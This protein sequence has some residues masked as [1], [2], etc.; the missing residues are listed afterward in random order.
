MTF[1]SDASGIGGSIT[2]NGGT[3]QIGAGGTAGSIGNKA[4]SLGGNTM[5]FNRS[6]NISYSGA[7]SGTSGNVTK[8]GAGTL[9]LSGN[10]A[11]TGALTVAGGTISVGVATN[12]GGGT[13]AISNGGKL[14]TSAGFT[15]AR[16]I[17]MATGGG[18]IEVSTAGFTN[19]AGLNGSG[20]LLKTGAGTLV[21]GTTAG[22]YSG[23]ATIG[24]GTLVANTTLSSADVT[25]SNTGTLMG[26]GTLDTVIVQSGG[27][28]SPGNSPGTL[29]VGAL[30][31][32][33]GGSYRWEITAAPGSAGTDWDLI[34][35]NGGGGLITL[36]ATSESKFTIDVVGSSPTGFSAGTSYT[37]DIIDAGSWSTAFTTNVFAINTN[38][39]SAAG[40]LG[41]WSLEDNSGNLRLVYTALATDYNVTVD[42]GATN[43]GAATGGA[44][45]F[46]GGVGV[47]KLG[48]GTL[49]MTNPLNDYT[50]VTTVKAGTVS[51]TANAPT[52]G[53]GSL[54][55]NTNAVAVGDIAAAN[56][57]GFNFGAAVTNDHGLNIVAGTGAADRTIGTTI[58]SGT[59]VQAGAV[60]LST[61]ATFTAASGG[62]LSV[63]GVI[64]GAGSATISG[65]GGTVDFTGN[66]TT[67]TGTTTLSSGTLAGRQRQRPRHRRPHP[68]RWPPGFGQ[69]HRLHSDQ[70]AHGRRQC[71]IRPSIRRDRIADALRCARPR[72]RNPQ[73]RR[74]QQHDAVGHHQR[75]RRRGV[76]QNG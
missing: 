31:L 5:V 53:V 44:A 51:I 75:Q 26:T 68:Q 17:T 63:S 27:T 25:I 18:T 52:N 14:F 45:L 46:T 3:L 29:S 60:T 43:Q 39:F 70:R 22:N 40:T 11:F 66:N 61:N 6:D 58:T 13:V 36:N 62:T 76:D 33:G 24:A 38:N 74:E 1:S 72:S 64:S 73:L 7:I 37:W 15:S 4:V 12:L 8:V 41:E 28:I 71:R 65:A 59:A 20:A 21:L 42:A 2:V 34:S 67:Y 55:N 16:A 47:N 32:E 9:T 54:G 50:G 49:V 19:T 10:N 35:V 30:T 57:A 56:A 48:A 23:T 69:R